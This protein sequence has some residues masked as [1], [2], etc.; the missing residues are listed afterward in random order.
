M[1][2]EDAKHRRIMM[3]IKISFVLLLSIMVLVANLTSFANANVHVPGKIYYVATW[4]SDDNDGSEKSP[5]LTIQH[6]ANTLKA[7]E[8]VFVRGGTYHENITIK[9][10]GSPTL[11]Y[12]TIQAYPNEIPVISGEKSSG[13]SLVQFRNAHYIIF[14]GFEL[15]NFRTSDG[16]KHLYGIKIIDA[17]SNLII[18]NNHIHHIEHKGADANANG[19]IVYGNSKTAIANIKIANNYL[20]DLVLGSSEALTVAGNV[21]GF[22]VENNVIE[23]VN[24]I[25]IDIAGFYG[26]CSDGCLDQARNGLV[27]GNNVSYVDTISNPAY[28]G[29]RAAAAIYVDGGANTIIERNEVSYSNYGFEISSENSNKAATK[30]ILRNNYIHHNHMSGLIMGG[31]SSDNGGAKENLILNNTFYSNNELRTGDGEITFQ[32]YVQNNVFVNNMFMTNKE[33]PYFY[34]N[35]PTSSG[36]KIDYNLY[37]ALDADTSYWR[38]GGTRYT[39]LEQFQ[40]ATKQDQNSMIADP[41]LITVSDGI[42]ALSE[43]SPAIDAGTLLHKEVGELDLMAAARVTGESIDIGAAEFGSELPPI[44]GAPTVPPITSPPVTEAPTAPPTTSPPA[45]EA[46]TAPPTSP[47]ATE[48]PTAP[49]TTSPPTSGTPTAPPI[50]SPPAGQQPFVIDGIADDWASY[51]AAATNSS[52]VKELKSI[53]VDQTLYVLV[54]GQLLKE[55]GQLY[56]QTN[57]SDHSYFAVPHWSNQQADY[58]IENGILYQYS[59]T[60]KNWSWKKLKDYRNREIVLNNTAIEMAIPLS[61]LDSQDTQQLHIGYIW[62]D[63][64]SNLLPAGGAMAAISRQASGGEPQPTTTPSPKPTPAPTI[65]IDGNMQDWSSFKAVS[66]KSDGSLAV[67]AT[68]DAEYLYVAVKSTT[69]FKKNQIYLNTDNNSA[70]G[71]QSSK[72][73]GSGVDYLVENGILYRYGGEGKNW[74]FQ[75]QVSL[76]KSSFASSTQAVELKLSLSQLGVKLGNSI[77]IGIMLDDRSTLKLPTEGAFVQYNLKR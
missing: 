36:N 54:S 62:K 31:S 8:T 49:P 44:T 1:I 61:D 17:S 27:A 60:G 34:D 9:S 74:L 69:S 59:G 66:E 2:L 68:H 13:S 75:K 39:S 7:G 25:G 52:N 32:N 3:G 58:L 41:K 72:W 77:T 70:T 43:G 20:H 73:K 51:P 53:I 6:A 4:G 65:K 16:S 12:I 56:I 45:T 29:Y 57:Q 67:Y 47:P 35:K 23:R 42:V 14:D 38:Y 11:G 55:K 26:A 50:T 40:K 21:D 71:Y 63:S 24:N 19:I 28:R 48:A 30:I 18:Q 37:Y 10:S 5:W 46:P 76:D 33:T 15:S 64:K 22:S